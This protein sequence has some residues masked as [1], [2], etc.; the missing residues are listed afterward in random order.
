[1]L[2]N[3][4]FYDTGTDRRVDAQARSMR[5]CH[6]YTVAPAR[7]R[8]GSL[9]CAQLCGVVTGRTVPKDRLTSSCLETTVTRR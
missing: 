2:S 3:S 9:V 6:G 4:G 1:M 5:F 8:P 7:I